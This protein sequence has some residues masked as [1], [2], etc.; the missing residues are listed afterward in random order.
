MGTG[1]YSPG[2]PGVKHHSPVVR[3]QLEISGEA[4]QLVITDKSWLSKAD[5]FG[6]HDCLNFERAALRTDF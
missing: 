2:L 6:R 1:W 5:A 3:A 4:N